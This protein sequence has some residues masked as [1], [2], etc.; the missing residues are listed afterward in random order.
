MRKSG[1]YDTIGGAP[2]SPKNE[3]YEPTQLEED[4]LGILEAA[5]VPESINDKI[6]ALIM[7]WEGICPAPPVVDE[8]SEQRRAHRLT[9]GPLP[10]PGEGLIP[11]LSLRKGK[12]CSP[13][14]IYVL[15]EDCLRLIGK[16]RATP[17]KE[18]H[19]Q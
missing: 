15:E 17:R 1:T 6:V 12:F 14:E 18:T 2:S 7:E 10:E 5:G 16:Y 4:V 11:V 3:G 13:N 8:Y 19:G 9:I